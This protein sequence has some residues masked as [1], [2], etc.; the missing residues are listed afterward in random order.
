MEGER[1]P[2]GW[3]AAGRAVASSSAQC[4]PCGAYIPGLGREGEWGGEL[5]TW[6]G[7]FLLLASTPARSLS[8]HPDSA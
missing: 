5:E 2:K 7:P 8:L 4:F 3:I 1:S 6:G